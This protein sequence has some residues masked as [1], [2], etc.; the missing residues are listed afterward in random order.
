MSTHAL[1]WW[2]LVAFAAVPLAGC[3]DDEPA[4][5]AGRRGG[6]AKKKPAAAAAA[7]GADE[8]ALLEKLPPKLRN[9]DWST[10]ADAPRDMR[11]TR[12]PFKR[13]VD[14]LLVVET[15]PDCKKGGK[16]GKDCPEGPEGPTDIIAG[17]FAVAELK[18]MA[19]ITGTAAHKAMLVDP[20][21]LGHMVRTG[22][23]VGRDTMRVERITRNEILFKPLQPPEDPSK[24]PTEL[25]KVL[26]SQEE[27]EE[28]LP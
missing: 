28:L 19:I 1:I 2:L 27:L 22:D 7:A 25:R 11:D 6:G 15:P 3:G 24:Q 21:R 12:D 17:R 5:P 14:D 10:G 18:L 4:A 20:G 9:V 8:Q 16:G 23:V 13:Y 26:L